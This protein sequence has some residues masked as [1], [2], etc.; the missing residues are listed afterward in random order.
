MTGKNYRLRWMIT[1]RTALVVFTANSRSGWATPAAASATRDRVKL[2][3][4]P[5][6]RGQDT[7]KLLVKTIKCTK[8]KADLSEGAL[9]ALD[10]GEELERDVHEAGADGAEV[11]GVDRHHEDPLLALLLAQVAVRQVATVDV[12]YVS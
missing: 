8:T 9:E 4:S 10:A 6:R 5:Q 7:S 3:L 2:A 1:L 12:E 11:H